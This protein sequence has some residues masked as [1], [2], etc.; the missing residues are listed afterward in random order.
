M[1]L[2]LPIVLSRFDKYWTSTFSNGHPQ[3]KRIKFGQVNLI[4]FLSLFKISNCDQL[5]ETFAKTKPH[6]KKTNTMKQQN[7][8]KISIITFS[9]SYFEC[10][11]QWLPI[12]DQGLQGRVLSFVRTICDYFESFFLGVVTNVEILVMLK[13]QITISEINIQFFGNSKS[14]TKCS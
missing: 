9:G 4:K 3:T 14:F 8:R 6:N 12:D 13:W 7:T 5:S 10:G 1:Q 2:T 11:N